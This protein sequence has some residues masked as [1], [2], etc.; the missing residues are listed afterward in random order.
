MRALLFFPLYLAAVAALSPAS[1]ALRAA[2]S[3]VVVSPAGVA[4]L[5]RLAAAEV[6]RYVYARTGTLLP[7]AP[8]LPDG[9][10]AIVI[11]AKNRAAV[12]SLY[13][14]AADLK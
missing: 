14:G 4:P 12:A 6:R 10:D 2:D 3:A 7:L 11:A 8:A 9:G 13:A 5:E 1:F